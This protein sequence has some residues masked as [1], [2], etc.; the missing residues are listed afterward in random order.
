MSE[1]AVQALDPEIAAFVEGFQL[2]L[3]PES[4]ADFRAPMGAAVELSDTVTR[5]DHTV[6]G[7]PDVT[8]R[9]HQPVGTKAGDGR[10]CVYSIH[11]GGYVLG[12]YEMDDAVFDRWCNS[13]GIVG[14]SVEYR[15][16]PDTPYPARSP[17]ATAG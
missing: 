4:L 11:G 3:T 15:L 16:A 1:P 8:V 6:P 14:V 10:P 9:V 2:T 5:T 12:S 7:D 13:L 17:T